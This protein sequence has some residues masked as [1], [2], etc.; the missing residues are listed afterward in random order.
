MAGYYAMI[1]E[2]EKAI[3]C[4]A[5]GGTRVTGVCMERL[6]RHGPKLEQLL[7]NFVDLARARD[8]DRGQAPKR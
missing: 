6:G 3:A 1:E 5:V 4:P 8:L 2:R 7:H